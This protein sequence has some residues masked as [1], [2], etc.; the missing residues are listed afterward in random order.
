MYL[1]FFLSFFLCLFYTCAGTQVKKPLVKA[2]LLAKSINTSVRHQLEQ[3]QELAEGKG[4][5]DLDLYPHT[6]TLVED[7]LVVSSGEHHGAASAPVAGTNAMQNLPQSQLQLLQVIEHLKDKIAM[8]RFFFFWSSPPP[9]FDAWIFCLLF[10]FV[11]DGRFV[12]FFFFFFFFLFLNTGGL[13]LK[14]LSVGAYRLR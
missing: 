14:T 8:V 11:S 4:V 2:N 1:S 7:P 13:L 6:T 9:N 3:V 10:V 5:E 12:F